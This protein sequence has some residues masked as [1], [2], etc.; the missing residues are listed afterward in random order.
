MTRSLR[1]AIERKQG[2]EAL[3]RS[4]EAAT[5]LA[6]ENAVLADIGRIVSS[7]LDVKEVYAPFADLVHPLIPF[8]RIVITVLDSEEGSATAS[9]VRGVDIPGWGSNQTYAIEGTLTDGVVRTR[10]GLIV[11][12]ESVEDFSARYPH[13][14]RASSTGLRSMIVVPLVSNDKAIGT[15]TL[16]SL[17]PDA[18]S[19]RDLA[20]AE[21]IGGQIAGALV[22]SGLLAQS[23]LAERELQ[24][25]KRAAEAA[26]RAKGEFLAN[27][28]HELRT[29]MSGIMSM[30]ELAL[31]TDLSP[32]QQEYLEAVRSSADSVLEVIN[33]VLDLSKIEAGKVDLHPVQFSLRDSLAE[34]LRT[35]APRAH[36]KGLE[37]AGNV[38]PDL[39]DALLGDVGRLR[40]ILVNL[41]DNAIKFTDRGQVVVDVEVRS[42]GDQHVMLHF[43]VSDTGVGIPKDNRQAIFEAFSQVEGAG[44]RSQTGTGLGLSIASQLVGMLGGKLW[45]ESPSVRPETQEG[46]PGSTFHFTARFDRQE[47]A[48]AVAPPTDAV[49]LKGVQVLVVDDN[50]TSRMFLEQ[51]LQSWEMRTTAASDGQRA[52]E[53]LERARVSG[54]PF[55]L[56]LADAIMPEMDG[57]SLAQRIKASPQLMGTATIVLTSGDTRRDAERCREI[58]IDACLPKPFKRSELLAAVTAVLIPHPQAQRRVPPTL[59]EGQGPRV[60]PLH[61]LVTEDNAVNRRATVRLLEKRGHTVATALDGREAL[62]ALARGHFDL[63]LMDIQMP[64]MDGLEATSAIREKE[65]NT[66]ERMPIVALTASAMKEDRERCLKAGM[67]GYMSKPIRAEE[68]YSAVEGF[69]GADLGADVNSPETARSTVPAFDRKAAL[70][71]AGGDEELLKETAEIFVD[72]SPRLL[73]D[74]REAVARRDGGALERSAH[75]LRGS[76][77]NFDAWGAF[78]AA[79]RLEALGRAADFAGVEEE[80]ERL[81]SEVRRLE[82]ALLLLAK[83]PGP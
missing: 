18:Y 51:T 70:A 10:T 14:A 31:D 2:E 7:S 12:G 68:L 25:A 62:D 66:G 67:D 9:Y 36:Q 55:P 39:P 4:E 40:Q 43:A 1:Y 71:R 19:Q 23:M 81:A 16:R 64:I 30:A 47:H 82:S 45:V 26:S 44:T 22:N 69:F 32:E 57:F 50:A 46:G 41:V 8:D 33:D 5:R 20:L 49:G 61:I 27:L 11:D 75:R 17:D 77:G 15:L 78:N 6:K 60:G 83:G 48:A 59:A 56:V 34:C 29:P 3:R 52:L 80:Y 72:E 79:K 73:A 58:G 54:E 37:L 24:K 53:E 21:R 35:F 65:K 28:S 38:E 76:A 13:E 63:V 74:V 42:H